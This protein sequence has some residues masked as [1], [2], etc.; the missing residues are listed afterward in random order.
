MLND[1]YQV[2]ESLSQNV[3][4]VTE[5]ESGVNCLMRKFD[6]VVAWAKEVSGLENF[7][8][9]V[10]LKDKFYEELAVVFDAG[11]ILEK[12]IVDHSDID[13][14]IIWKVFT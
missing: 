11:D 12:Y 6:D 14:Q 1:K 5:R 3:F 2:G 10:Q 4:K 9:E 8:G 13:E 7:C